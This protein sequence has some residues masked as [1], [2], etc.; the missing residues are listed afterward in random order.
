MKTYGIDKTVGVES[1]GVGVDGRVVREPPEDC[2]SAK[3]P[4]IA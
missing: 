3:V 4:S 2:L 1:H